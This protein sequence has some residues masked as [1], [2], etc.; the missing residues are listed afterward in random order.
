M[1]DDFHRAKLSAAEFRSQFARLALNRW[2][3]RGSLS[4]RWGKRGKLNRRCTRGELH[5]SLYLVQSQ[6]GKLRQICVPQACR[7]AYDR[8][9]VTIRKCRN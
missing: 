6:S 3:L 2:F 5:K 4:Q 9:S 8:P 7:N 1:T